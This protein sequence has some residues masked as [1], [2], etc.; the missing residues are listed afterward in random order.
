[1]LIRPF[2]F[3]VNSHYAPAHFDGYSS[4][5]CERFFPVFFLFLSIGFFVVCLLYWSRS[6]FLLALFYSTIFSRMSFYAVFII[7]LSLIFYLK[8]VLMKE[9]FVLVLLTTLSYLNFRLRKAS[10]L[11]VHSHM[12]VVAFFRLVRTI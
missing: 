12:S 6:S 1:L 9:F 8:L 2:F 4:L 11:E 7:P 10:F 3:L 5:F